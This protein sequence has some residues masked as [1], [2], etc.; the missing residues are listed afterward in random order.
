MF[1]FFK[2]KAPLNLTDFDFKTVPY[3]YPTDHWEYIKL[4]AVARFYTSHA[5]EEDFIR[6]NIKGTDGFVGLVPQPYGKEMYAIIKSGGEFIAH[7]KQIKPNTLVINCQ[8]K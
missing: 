6:I 4:D 5:D 1:S 3:N 7:V 2:K 8:L